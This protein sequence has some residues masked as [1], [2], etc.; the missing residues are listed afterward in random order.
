M[1]KHRLI[2]QHSSHRSSI[3]FL[4]S[5]CLFPCV[6]SSLFHA[7]E[8]IQFMSKLAADVALL[9]W[10]TDSVLDLQFCQTQTVKQTAVLPHRFFF[11][12]KGC[13]KW[14]RQM[15]RHTLGSREITPRDT[16]TSCTLWK[17]TS[18]LTGAGERTYAIT[19]YVHPP[20]HVTEGPSGTCSSSCWGWT[21]GCSRRWKCW[22][23]AKTGFDDETSTVK[24]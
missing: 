2:L 11:S 19:T 1:I 7:H 24:Q 14:E 15:R 18:L 3:P 4:L 20:V 8:P 16:A 13:Y 9:L 17:L 10:E 5:L 21:V 23:V 12:A 6:A 22:F